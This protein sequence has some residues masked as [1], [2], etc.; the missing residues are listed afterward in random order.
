MYRYDEFDH[1]FVHQRVAQFRDQ[2]ARR[3]SGELSE[4]EF[5]PLRLMNGLYLQ[6]HAYMLRVAV[7][8]GVL[9]A[10]QLRCLANISRRYDKGYGHITTRQNI[11]YNWIKLDEMPDLLAKLAEV[12]MHAIQTSG[13]CIRNTT[14][15]H[16]AGAAA[17]EIE[18]PRV[19]CEIIRQW[20]TL[21][22][23]F[24]FLPRKFKIAVSG[25]ENDRA[26]LRVHDI[27]L[28]L[29]H[30]EAG[31]TGFEVMVGGG[32]GRTP[33]IAK[34]IREFLPKEHLLSYLESILRVYNQLGRRDNM[35]KARIKILVHEMGAETLAAQVEAEWNQVRDGFVDLPDQ[36]VARIDR[37]FAAPPFEISPGSDA[38]LDTARRDDSEFDRWLEHNV[39]AHKQPGYAIV[40]VSLKPVG[41]VPGDID[42]GQMEA[43]ADLAERFS[44]DE[45]RATHHQNLVLPHVRKRDLHAVWKILKGH[46]LASANRGLVG[47][48]IACPGMDYCSLATAR[49]IP[50]AQAISERFADVTY[51]QDIGDLRL[52]ISGCINACGHHHV[53]HIGIL[54]LDKKGSE[55]YQITLGGRA[56][57][58]AAI[59]EIIGPAFSADQ[60]VDAVE[61]VLR[62]YLDL[63]KSGESFIDAY[64]R[65]G[66][67]PFKE[68]LYASH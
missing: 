67:E 11:Q 62:T 56:D 48:I 38:G 57:N 51:Q 8:Y 28:Q 9:S 21:H 16:F 5:K 47:D 22:P 23:E 35:Y 54:G 6:L 60:I 53:G 41:G 4:D 26:A 37:Y 66:R 20:S 30:N 58:K 29:R 52:N 25:A 10:R 49:S 63:R 14:A 65:M 1:A 32:Q 27:G 13:N 12:E 34:T 64:A 68:R 36:E 46:G 42:A 55:N 59:G 24:S 19:W 50:V 7:P 40:T 3:L 33:M 43:V 31:E 15:D 45:L 39:D 44:F 61:T 2:V 17:D 18:D